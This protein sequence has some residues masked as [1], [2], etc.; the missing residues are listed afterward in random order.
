M[1]KELF[2]WADLYMQ[3]LNGISVDAMKQTEWAISSGWNKT[4]SCVD[5]AENVV[6]NSPL[7]FPSYE[8]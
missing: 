3:I 2:S 5:H 1:K 7:M 6:I 4:L 8:N